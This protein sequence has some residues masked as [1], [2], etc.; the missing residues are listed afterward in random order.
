MVNEI[1]EVR[2]RAGISRRSVGPLVGRSVSWG[3]DLCRG[4]KGCSVR[5]GMALARAMTADREEMLWLQRVILQGCLERQ[6]LSKADAS[7]AAEGWR[8]AQG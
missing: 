2:E 7:A 6:G 5:D 3:T 4:A 8:D 1:N